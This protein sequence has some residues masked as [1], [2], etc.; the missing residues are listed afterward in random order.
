[1]N[2]MNSSAAPNKITYGGFTLL[3]V[4]VA[5]VVLSIGLL[6][7][8][9]LQTTS[10]Q[11]NTG[12]Y[13]RTQATYLA[14]DIIDRMR[15][16]GDAVLAGAGYDIGI[17]SNIVSTYDSC[18]T[19]SCACD[20]ASCSSNNLATYDLGKWFD[21]T[22]KTLPDVATTPPTIQIDAARQATVTINWKER[23]L[24]LS[25]SWVVQLCVVDELC[26]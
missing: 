18:K 17:V 4:L 10:L 23:D 1:M 25:Q 8:A 26:R 13:Y 19:T 5:L 15:A 16:N 3:E 11:F 21:R 20:T 6:G 24:Q 7:L 14:Y 12:S 22:R 2:A 9:A